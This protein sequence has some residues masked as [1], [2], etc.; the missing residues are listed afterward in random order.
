MKEGLPLG[1]DGN[2]SVGS[3]DC[4]G[5]LAIRG[6]CLGRNGLFDIFHLSVCLPCG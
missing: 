4:V 3:A 2:T 5:C 1:Q 6:T